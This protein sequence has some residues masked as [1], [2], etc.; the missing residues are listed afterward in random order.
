MTQS[1]KFLCFWVFMLAVVDISFFLGW[2]PGRTISF[3]VAR[4]YDETQWARPAFLLGG[5]VL[6]AVLDW[7]F[8]TYK[9]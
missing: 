1:F 6:M 3:E 5:V 9:R 7:H 2:L 8:A 4:L